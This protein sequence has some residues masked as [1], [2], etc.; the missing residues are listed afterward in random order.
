MPGGRHLQSQ[1]ER[2]HWKGHSPSVI[3]HFSPYLALRYLRPK[4]TFVSVI[5]LIS[6]AGVAAGVAILIIVIGIMRGFHAQITDLA[7][8]YETHIETADNAGTAMLPSGKRPA[9]AEVK[10]W[11]DVLKAVRQTPGVLSASPMVRGLVLLESAEGMAPAGMW[12]VTEEDGNRLV[13]KHKKLVVD[14]E[15]DLS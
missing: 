3:K 2:T 4:R 1:R 7:Q 11:R 15:L 12:G 10:S 5:T 9:D 14:G 8:G 6:I 13:E